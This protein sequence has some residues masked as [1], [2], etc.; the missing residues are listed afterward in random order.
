MVPFDQ[1]A[2]VTLGIG[3]GGMNDFSDQPHRRYPGGPKPWRNDAGVTTAS[4]AFWA[5][6]KGRTADTDERPW[7]GNDAKLLVDYVRV[8]AL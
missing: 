4:S 2:Y 7:P 5:A 1:R 6:V 3:V 8:Y